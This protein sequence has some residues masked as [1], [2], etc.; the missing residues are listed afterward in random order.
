MKM[1]NK[2]TDKLLDR[3]QN[4]YRKLASRELRK[5]SLLQ[6]KIQNHMQA[7]VFL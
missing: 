6:R 4:K 7:E 5:I 2:E 3:K 1:I